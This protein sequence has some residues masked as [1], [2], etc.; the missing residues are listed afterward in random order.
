MK[1]KNYNSPSGFFFLTTFLTIFL[2]TFFLGFSLIISLSSRGLDKSSDCLNLLGKSFVV[3]VL[4]GIGLF[5]DLTGS[6]LESICLENLSGETLSSCKLLFGVFFLTILLTSTLFPS[7]L[8]LSNT[9]PFYRYNNN[10][11]LCLGY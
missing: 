5:D 11:P 2:T 1:G 10:L 7:S 8:I 6:C 4:L 3:A 9:S